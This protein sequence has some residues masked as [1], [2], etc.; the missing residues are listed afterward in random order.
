MGDDRAEESE[1]ESERKAEVTVIIVLVT[2]MALESVLIFF[3]VIRTIDLRERLDLSEC[4][5]R[6]E[7]EMAKRAGEK[8]LDRAAKLAAIDEILHPKKKQ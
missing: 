1:A 4:E 5:F 8:S 3:L 7:R 6:C 2:A